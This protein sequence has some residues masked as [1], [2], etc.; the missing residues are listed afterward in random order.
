MNTSLIIFRCRISTSAHN[1]INQ[2]D[3]AVIETNIPC[4]SASRCLD[5]R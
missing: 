3:T 4:F 1:G 5:A 2:L